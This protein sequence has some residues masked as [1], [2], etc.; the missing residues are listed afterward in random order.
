MTESEWLDAWEL[1]PMLEAL[2]GKASE[3]KLRLF[4]VAV[5]RRI[6]RLLEDDR[7]RKAVEV[8]EGQAEGPFDLEELAVAALGAQTA[9]EEAKAE[10]LDAVMAAAYAAY[11]ASSPHEEGAEDGI[12]WANHAFM[13]ALSATCRARHGG[14]QGTW[15]AT[16]KA[17]LTESCRLLRDLF[18]NPFR[19][20]PAIDPTW[21]AWDGGL[22]QR[23]AEDAYEVRSLPEGGL[24]N[25]RLAVLADALEDAGCTNAELLDHLRDPGPHV[26]GCFAV[27]WVLG[28][29]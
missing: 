28:K 29:A 16:A 18:G 24:D 17:E 4:A 5:C 2:R 25:A 20:P 1:Q 11:S 23:L 13:M 26:R 15:H 3:R 14:D 10:R 8:A 7:L 12:S 22:V 21:L 27:D 9:A 6:W 19:P